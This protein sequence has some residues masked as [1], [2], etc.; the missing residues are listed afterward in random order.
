MH[1]W[2]TTVERLSGRIGDD[3]KSGQGPPEVLTLLAAISEAM[4]IE[5]AGG[6]APAPLLSKLSGLRRAASPFLKSP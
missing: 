1:E 4:A 2:A 5:E 6:L 3:L